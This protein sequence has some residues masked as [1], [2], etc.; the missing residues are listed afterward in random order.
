M[1]WASAVTPT[2]GLV[3]RGH[4]RHSRTQWNVG[5]GGFHSGEVTGPS[6]GADPIFRYIYDCGSISARTALE[7]CL[8][9]YA[10]SLG[11]RRTV[12]AIFL[13]HIDQDHVNGLPSLLGKHGVDVERIF[14]PLLTPVERLLTLAR[15]GLQV[16]SALVELVSDP[17][18]TLRGM[19]DAEVIQVTA[20]DDPS[21]AGDGLALH[22]L[23]NEADDSLSAQVI[24][25]E[26]AWTP[27]AGDSA[28]MRDSAAVRISTS[29]AQ[30]AWL[31]GFYIEPKSHGRIVDFVIE[32]SH[33]LGVAPD[34][35]ESADA[36]FIRG[37]L[38]EKASLAAL[39]RAYMQ[40]NVD[41]NQGSLLM[42]SGPLS[43][44]RDEIIRFGQF[45]GNS[46]GTWLL[47]GDAKLN[48]EAEVNRLVAHF[49]SRIE[50]TRVL[51]LPH[52]G[53]R[54][55][56]HKSLLEISDEALFMAFASAGSKRTNWSHPDASVVRDVA[57]SSTIPW[58]ATE[59]AHTRITGEMQ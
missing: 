5:Q 39:R 34:T 11:E 54:N 23:G 2:L 4:L 18:A 21:D 19:S 20:A 49:G 57:S 16:T 41:P 58:V 9:A 38:T 55:N 48:S 32:L 24:G 28:G 13:S 22:T 45:R 17:V 15:P 56:F 27:A 3:N 43:V 26:G 31:L 40:A 35:I 14:L 42:L 1:L 50:R 7:S 8:A 59:S 6:S 33:A 10:H 12:D 30:E 47:T 53:S 44:E 36:T 29:S 46:T 25:R 52:H 37:L 51:G